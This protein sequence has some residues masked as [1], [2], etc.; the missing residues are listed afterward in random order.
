[1]AAK[2]PL[3][4]KYRPRTLEEYVFPNDKTEEIVRRWIK[5]G[6]IPHTLLVSN[7]GQGKTTLVKVLINELGIDA[8]DVKYINGSSKNG[9]GTIREEIE[10][11]L[12]K[13][14]FSKFKIVFFDEID[15]LS[16][17]AQDSLKNMIEENTNH[18]RFV[19]TANHLHKITPA[20]QSR[21]KAGMLD[22]NGVSEEKVIELVAHILEE[23]EIE[24]DDEEV[25]FEHIGLYYPDFRS[26]IN[27]IEAST[28]EGVLTSPIDFKATSGSLADWEEY[29]MSD[30]EL[31]YEVLLELT[32]GIDNNNFEGF[33][34]VMYENHSKIPDPITGIKHLS[35]YLDRAMRSA[36]QRLHMDAC[37][38]Q[39]FVIEE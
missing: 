5:E 15:G 7:A 37:I 17:Q 34:Q 4:E 33:Y 10:P 28:I 36:N 8:S 25:V 14:S 21:F 26:I 39:L 35:A 19:G 29:W 12:K 11:W 16:P 9:I 13:S 20:L 38:Y 23:E 1:M 22:M 31:D 2:Q 24:I 30:E 32:E 18:V 3:N 27:S 6:S